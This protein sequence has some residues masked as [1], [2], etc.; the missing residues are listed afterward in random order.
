[1]RGEKRYMGTQP[2]RTVSVDRRLLPARQDLVNHSPDG[3]EW[4]YEGSG[5]SQLALAI[6][7]DFIQ[8]DSVALQLYQDFKRDVI[9]KL[10]QGK[11][12]VISGAEV[13]KWIQEHKV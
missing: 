12:W 10:E 8:N 4:G 1:M 7:C 6:L 9:A 13:Q 5:P 11:D 2:S 3:F